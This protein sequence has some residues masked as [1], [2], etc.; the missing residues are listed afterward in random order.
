VS[1]TWSS[2]DWRITLPSWDDLDKKLRDRRCACI[3][4]AGLR[5][6]GKTD[7][8][9]A[10]CQGDGIFGD[11]KR[12]GFVVRV[13]INADS[14]EIARLLVLGLCAKVLGEQYDKRLRDISDDPAWKRALISS[15]VAIVAGSVL[16]VLSAKDIHLNPQIDLG[17][18]L[19][20]AGVVGIL[21]LFA[22][23]LKGSLALPGRSK[24]S[25]EGDRQAQKIAADLARGLEDERRFETTVT[26]G[27]TSGL[28]TSS[29]NIGTSGSVSKRLRPMSLREL[30]VRYGELVTAFARGKDLLVGI[31]GL[32]KRG[33]L[34]DIDPVLSEL[35]EFLRVGGCRYLIALQENP[36]MRVSFHSALLDDTVYCE[37]LTVDKAPEIIRN[38]IPDVRADIDDGTSTLCFTAAGGLPGE[39]VKMVRFVK[40]DSAGKP[41]LALTCNTLVKNELQILATELRSAARALSSWTGQKRLFKWAEELS[42]GEPKAD[43]IF[44]ISNEISELI[45]DETGMVSHGDPDLRLAANRAAALSYFCATLLGFFADACHDYDMKRARMS[46]AD[47][48]DADKSLDRLAEAR[49]LIDLRTCGQAW[50]EIHDFRA[51]WGMPVK[52]TASD[53]AD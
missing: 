42:Y 46:D 19:V 17:S 36:E 52:P 29:M 13:P 49:R 30:A 10:A 12:P 27:W 48:I 40:D 43:R 22:R 5:S 31:D 34:A 24:G 16:L 7:L 28:S 9:Y 8:I 41:D 1:D 6:T 11:P 15:V 33:S 45:A 37:L 39:I 21:F 3:G 23:G 51:K 4:V 32:D 26:S 50:N 18:V 44:A 35:R 53:S 20:L 47:R 2:E 25:L 38:R 14:S